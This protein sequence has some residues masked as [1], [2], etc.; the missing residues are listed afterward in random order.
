MKTQTAP[1]T[2]ASKAADKKSASITLRKGSEMLTL[3][4]VLRRQG[5]SGHDDP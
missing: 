3:L 2:T 4:A 1:K 5:R